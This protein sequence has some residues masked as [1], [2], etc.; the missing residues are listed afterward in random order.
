MGN[1]QRLLSKILAAVSESLVPC[2]VGSIMEE[3]R[4]TAK[5]QD[6][7][8]CPQKAYNFSDFQARI[9]SHVGQHVALPYL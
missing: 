2:A 7:F 8:S 1:V 6:L 4:T 5:E 9:L 3:Y